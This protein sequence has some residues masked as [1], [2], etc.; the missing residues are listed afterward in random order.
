[1]DNALGDNRALADQLANK[2]KEVADLRACLKGYEN[3]LGT[4]KP[5][6]NR[7]KRDADDYRRR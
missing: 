7:L 2:E 1:L 6:Y 5:D 3:E 4:I